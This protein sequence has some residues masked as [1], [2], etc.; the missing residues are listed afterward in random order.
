MSVAREGIMY[1]GERGRLLTGYMA[2]TPRVL[3][4]GRSPYR[5]AATTRPRQRPF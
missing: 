2:E 1:S 3:T 4:A 5:P